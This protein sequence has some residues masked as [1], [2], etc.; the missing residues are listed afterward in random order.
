MNGLFAVFGFLSLFC[1]IGGVAL[2]SVV[3]GWRK[4]GLSC[5]SIFFVIWGGLFA[6]IPLLMGTV[7]FAAHSAVYLFGIQLGLLIGTILLVA[8]VPDAFLESFDFAKIAPVA[9]GGLFLLI[10]VVVAVTTI[11]TEPLMALLFLVS[12]GG[13]GGALFVQSIR[14]ALKS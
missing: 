13:I 6:G 11:T 4:K 1:V 3:R 9:F 2:G 8:F 10:G 12:F 5:N 14:D 7:L